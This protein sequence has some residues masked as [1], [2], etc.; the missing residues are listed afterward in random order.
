MLFSSDIYLS[1]KV[2][3]HNYIAQ[4]V[5]AVQEVPLIWNNHW[6]RLTL[7]VMTYHIVL[8]YHISH[9]MQIDYQQQRSRLSSNASRASFE[10]AVSLG[11]IQYFSE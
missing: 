5:A 2:A 7:A 11:K 10:H 9:I 6:V 1:L 4:R 3:V 8:V